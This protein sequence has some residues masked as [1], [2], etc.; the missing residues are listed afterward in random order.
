[1]R[2]AVMWADDHIGVINRFGQPC[3]T[4]YSPER[5]KSVAAAL[6]EGGCC[7]TLLCRCVK[8]LLGR[9]SDSCQPSPKS[10]ARE[11]FS[12]WRTEFR[13]SAVS[14]R[15]GRARNGWCS[16]HRLWPARICIGPR[17]S[18][19]QEAHLRSRRADAELFA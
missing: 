6:Q 12:T 10:A 11:S 13:A 9:S 19:R 18:Y 8:E 1:M 7:E 16:I 5:V 14:P 17:Q 2:I 15:S 4:E 3:P